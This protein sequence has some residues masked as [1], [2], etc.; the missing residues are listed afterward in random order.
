MTMF[1]YGCKRGP[2]SSFLA[3]GNCFSWYH[4]AK[5]HDTV[6]DFENKA[7][8]AMRDDNVEGDGDDYAN[9]C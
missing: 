8:A 7:M 3:L 4:S 6:L 2:L 1:I 5:N 9:C